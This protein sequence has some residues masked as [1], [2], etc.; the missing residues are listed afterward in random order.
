MFA[1]LK[2]APAAAPLSLAL[3]MASQLAQA[4]IPGMRGTQHFGFTVPDRQAAV[5][6]FVDV[7]G[8]EAFFTI[9]PFGPFDDDWM[10]VNLDVHAEATIPAAHLVRCGNGTNLEIFEY[11]APDQRTEQPRN[12]D[13]GG[14][15]IAFYV[16][17]M[18]SAVA[19]LKEND[20]EVLGEPKT[21]TEGPMEGLSWVYFMAPWG[22]QLELVS[23]PYGMGYEAETGS[24]LWDPRF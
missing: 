7:I 16:D 20:V 1:T 5:D 8:C 21:F 22:M 10:D 14:H 11:T 9:G 19:Y 2:H 23:S 15:H 4:E 3:L 6:F 13:I 12:S 18:A 17:D 24:R